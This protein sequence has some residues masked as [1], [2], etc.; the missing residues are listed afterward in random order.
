[1][2]ARLN[3]YGLLGLTG[4]ATRL[5]VACGGDG[6]ELRRAGARQQPTLP[7]SSVR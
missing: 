2:D 6:D 7:E 3:P 1:M 5:V 4:R